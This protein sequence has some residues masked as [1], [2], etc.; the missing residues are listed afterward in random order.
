MKTSRPSR[1]SSRYSAPVIGAAD[2]RLPVVLGPE[3][4]SPAPSRD[5][6]VS[7]S[8]PALDNRS[9][10][11]IEPDDKAGRSAVNSG[12]WPPG[13]SSPIGQPASLSEATPVNKTTQ[14]GGD[15]CFGQSSGL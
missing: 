10:A 2:A 13:R 3:G 6:I 9:C 12:E 1:S 7:M 15:K 5:A 11:L 4:K 14:L 8:S